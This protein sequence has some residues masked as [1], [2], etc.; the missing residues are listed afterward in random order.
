LG[1]RGRIATAIIVVST[2][3]ILVVDGAASELSGEEADVAEVAC[4]PASVELPGPKGVLV[5]GPVRRIIPHI[6]RE[7]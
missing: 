5:Q 2:V 1:R 4:T 6:R 7:E 3:L